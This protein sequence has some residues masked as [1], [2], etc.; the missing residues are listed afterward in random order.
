[1]KRFFTVV[2]CLLLL[3]SLVAGC[4]KTPQQQTPQEETGLEPNKEQVV[5]LV[6]SSEISEWN[7]LVPS[8]AGDY[9]NYLDHLVEYDYFGMCQPCLA[10]S[11]TKSEDGLTWTFKIRK[12]VKWM[13]WDG[14]EYGEDVTAHDFVTT[15][16]YILDSNNA[17]RT[18]DL[19]FV[20]EGAEKYYD[21]TTRPGVTPDWSKVG[22]RALDDYTLEFKLLRP[23]PYFLSMLTYNWG[24][25]T[26]AKFLEEMGE[27]FG[28]GPKTILYC[29]AFLCSEYE[30]ESY[31]IDTRN[32][33]YWDAEDIY[34]ERIERRYN[35]EAA[36]LAPELLL[37]GEVTYA[38]I[39]ATQLD[40]WMNDPEKAKLIRPQRGSSY[41]Y[42]Y[43]F[44]FWPN[45]P[46]QYD[47]ENWLKAVNNL[48]F[49]KSFYY[50]LDRIA[51]I[52]CYDPYTPENYLMRTITPKDFVAAGGKDFTQLG[53]LAE[54]SSTDQHNLELALKYKEQAMRELAEVGCKFPVKVYMPYNTGTS[55]QV[56]LAQVTEQQLERDLGTDY[57]DIIIEGYPNTDFLNVTRRA[58]NYCFMMSYWGPDYADP[59]TYTDP[60]AIGQKYGYCYM[61]EG[62]G[63]RTTADD[64]EGRKGFDGG[65]WKNV[66]YDDM[67]REAAQEVVDLEKRYTDFANIEAW[68]ID[69]AFVVPLGRLGATYYV[70]S[71]MNPF[72]SQYAPFG[73]SSSRYKYQKVM[74]KPMDTETFLRLQ[75]EWEKARNEAIAKAQAEGRDY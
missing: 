64:P 67:V 51:C 52:S 29:G 73:A 57:I 31:R 41:S 35:A 47:R 71:Y 37:R 55:S 7:Y 23:L 30:P 45:F 34:V 40:E 36:T 32:P 70:S 27:Q 38:D 4:G 8:A 58:G 13:T 25:P 66:T 5:K 15:A 65:Y 18:A 42:F 24:Y 28:T 72:E 44:N 48:A 6:Y 61:A 22:I 54:I 69:Q 9:A 10:E 20:F 33:T 56:Q 60:F 74:A 17:C 53:D 2:V 16:K 75:E 12:G 49:R 63:E 19:M 26:N 62:Y 59:E 14:K 68:L 21:E 46:E 43:L 50:A 3:A 39:P 11:W 1:M